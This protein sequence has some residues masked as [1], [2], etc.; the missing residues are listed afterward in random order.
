MKP[1][2]FEYVRPGSLDEALDTLTEHGYDAKLLAGGQSLVPLLNMRFA[3]PEIIVDINRLPGLDGIAV[4]DGQIRAGALVRQASFEAS[5]EVRRSLPLV[6]EC[7]PFIGHFVTRNRGTVGGSIAHADARAELPLAIAALGG[8]V[9]VSSKRGTRTIGAEDFFVTHFT[10]TLEPDEIVVDTSWPSAEAGCGYAFE[11]F[12]Q[13]AG[14]YAL[15]M[16]ACVI[17]AENGAVAEARVVLGAT[18]ERPTLLAEVAECLQGIDVTP[19]SARE[20]GAL[21]AAAV[22]PMDGLHASAAYQRHLTG[23]LVERA[24]MRAWQNV[25]KEE[26]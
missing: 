8:S 1:A 20:A 21:A 3:R 7:I 13:R 16:T 17:R 6:A 25:T 10:S 22:E 18:V 26:A 5:S 11:E 4:E 24:V 2:P 15:G 19:E 23:V 14:D 12:A 9:T